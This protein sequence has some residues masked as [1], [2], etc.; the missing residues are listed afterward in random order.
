MNICFVCNEYPPV[1]GGGIGV[2]VKTLA[3]ALV[4]EGVKVF[5]LGYGYKENQPKSINGVKI[6]WLHLPNPLYKKVKI[7]GYPYSI[8]S[9]I[10]RH[11]L[12]LKLN[13]LVRMEKIDIVESY[14]FSGPLAYKPP[15]P[16][17][18]RLHGATT[19]YRNGEGRPMQINPLDRHFEVKNVKMADHVLAV[20]SHIGITTN[21][22]MGF[23]TPYKVIF[24]CVDTD[25][26]F[27]QK[28]DP[29]PE[30][31]LFV[32]NMMW[33]K[34]LFDLIHAMPFIL[35]K[36]PDVRLKVVGGSSGSHREQLEQSLLSIGGAVNKQIDILG[37]VPHNELPKIFNQASVFVFPS[38]V[39]AF[40][41][42]CVEAMACARP[43]V[44]TSLASG[45]ELVE[46]G[47]SGLLADPRD[48]QDLASKICY[49][50]ENPKLGEKL[51]L[52]ARQRVLE[53]FDL[54]DLGHKNLDFYT[55]II[56]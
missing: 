9:L 55:S 53:R 47:V 22:V 34:G 46:D 5:V 29:T 35:E 42:T 20:S 49:I 10:R 4:K 21:Q 8:A 43:V 44:A 31:I 23:D 45:P 15:C 28:L 19:V 17:V 16:L 51:G 2:F 7:G 6:H 1:S 12:S 54:K 48:P 50:L 32:G 3:E 14:D 36:H 24:N 56:K 25:K 18:I 38:R 26:F 27:P 33:R 37:K 41:L 13:R 40:G 52:A 11:Y 39:E 30:T